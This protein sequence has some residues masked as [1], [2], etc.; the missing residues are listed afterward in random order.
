MKHVFIIGAILLASTSAFAKDYAKRYPTDTALEVVSPDAPSDG[1]TY[2]RKDAGW[3]AVS[4]TESDPLS[5]HLDQTTSQDIINTSMSGQSVQIMDGTQAFD[6]YADYGMHFLSP[7]AVGAGTNFTLDLFNYSSGY[8]LSAGLGSKTLTMMNGSSSFSTTDGTSTVSLIDGTF[9]LNVSGESYFTDSV[10]VA[11]LAGPSFDA[12]GYFAHNG[13]N[14]VTL[15]DGTYSINASGLVNIA[16][17]TTDSTLRVGSLELQ[18][19]SLGNSW[20]GENVYFNGSA[21]KYRD[22]GTA[23]IFRFVGDEGQFLHWVSGT[24]GDDAPYTNG[25][26]IKWNALGQFGLGGKNGSGISHATDDFTGVQVYKSPFGNFVVGNGTVADGA[27]IRVVAP[28]PLDY[29]T[30]AYAYPDTGATSYSAEGHQHNYRIY[31]YRLN[32]STKEFFS[33]NYAEV[34]IYYDANNYTPSFS[35]NPYAQYDSGYYYSGANSFDYV[36]W[37]NAGGIWSYYGSSGANVTD[38]GSS[39]NYQIYMEWYDTY[40]QSYRVYKYD[41]TTSTYYYYDTTSPS[42]T[43]DGTWTASPD[44]ASYPT[45]N[46]YNMLVDWDDVTGADGYIVLKEDTYSGIY[47]STL[48]GWD[49]TTSSL[50]DSYDYNSVEDPTVSSTA[51]ALYASNDANAT[52]SWVK[53]CKGSDSAVEA[54]IDNSDYTTPNGV[55]SV[56]YLR[57][58][59][60]GGQ[61]IV[62]SEIAGNMVAKWR[63]DYVGNISW[64]AGPTGAHDFYVGGDYGTG[65]NPFKIL[66]NGHILMNT[67]SDSASYGFINNHVSNFKQKVYIDPI[68]TDNSLEIGY[69]G[70]QGY[71]LNNN[72]FGDNIKFNGSAFVRRATGYAGMFYFA[73]QEGTFR[74]FPSGN[75]GTATGSA[76]AYNQM[77]INQDGRW[78]IGG[79]SA[80]AIETTPGSFTGSQIYK[81]AAG[82][83]YIEADNQKVFWGTGTGIGSGDASLYYDGTNF[84]INPKEIGSGY[85]NVKGT[86]RVDDNA[87]FGTTTY[88]DYGNSKYV[89]VVGTNPAFQA[90]ASTGG[91]YFNMF[92]VT[93]SYLNWGTS[94]NTSGKRNVRLGNLNNKLTMDLLNDTWNVVLTANIFS[95]AND[96][97]ANSFNIKPT[98]NLLL[99]SDTDSTTFKLQVTGTSLFKDKIAFTQT[100]GEEYIDSL[101]DGYMDYRATTAHRFGDGTN[102]LQIDA[103][104]DLSLVGTAKYERHIQI[105]A[106]LSGTPANQPSDID[107]GSAG[108]LQFASTPSQ[109]VF[110]QWEVPDDWD[111]GDIYFEVD[112]FPDS[113]ATSGTDTVEWTI[114]YRS[115]AE[116]E[117]ITNGTLKTLTSTDSGDYAQYRTKH[118]RVTLPYN[119]AN[120]PLTKQD[121][122]YFKITRNTGVANDFA[123]TVTVT[124]YE[125]IYNSNGLPT[126]N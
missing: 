12:G 2:G 29:P 47:F 41:N 73:G 77:K 7:T 5:L 93:E 123:G 4:V 126:S 96:A 45:P 28:V 36:I 59:N 46:Q 16:G 70:L 52:K 35:T 62:Y 106:V 103:D 66:N 78:G 33:A 107:F 109:S 63:T 115:I 30:N 18:N 23:G 17:S 44:N 40:P 105:P 1:T 101:A 56:L 120:Q 31:P 82:A 49:V 32:G 71:A 51:T 26:Q 39:G 98:G 116:G 69:L 104:G 108:G 74:F 67:Q 58:T 8:A 34:G 86:L 125:V 10:N 118:A 110:T 84:I 13:Q 50:N 119:D 80:S 37:A 22:T 124:A 55:G 92:G 76:G 94:N 117:T 102:Y 19:Y 14:I 53:L 42:A 90:Q 114:D 15:S 9:A 43:D 100:D 85:L 65:N 91:A 38:D 75:A 97:P 48:Y 113:G 25:V 99:G 111:G 20:F 122:I 83:L 95:I 72:W 57:N 64:V 68:S 112:W 87:I 60:S 24:G 61:N 3:T 54:M 88:T 11:H 81:A 27:N 79:A 21:F 121:H 6:V 89:G